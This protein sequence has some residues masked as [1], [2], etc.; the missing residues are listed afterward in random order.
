M[1]QK[2]S[3]IFYVKY[4]VVI[5][6]FVECFFRI[7]HSIKLD[8]YDVLIKPSSVLKKYYT[9]IDK[10]NSEQIEDNNGAIDI[11]LLGGSV[12][13]SDWSTIAQEL[14]KKLSASYSCPVNIHNLAIPAHTSLD[15][16]NKYNVL[17]HQNYDIV[18]LYHG[19]NE[20]RFN[21][22]PDSIFKDDY[23]HVEFYNHINSITTSLSKFTI[24]PYTYNLLKMKILEKFGKNMLPKGT[25][26]KEWLNYGSDIKTANAF[27]KNYELIVELAK[28]NN[29]AVV[30]PT[31]GICFPYFPY[32]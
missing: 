31:F 27:Y 10:A 6:L 5:L 12:L 21:N 15:S 30:I 4:F 22:C 16:K 8:N 29:T 3:F 24:L 32:D 7:Y 9:G 1:K 20:V 26:Y 19:I 11:L 14:N 28:K 23:S 17:A 2:S 13:H 25:P 18:L